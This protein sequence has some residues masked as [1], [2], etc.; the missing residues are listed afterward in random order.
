MT[1]RLGEV[2]RDQPLLALLYGRGDKG[3]PSIYCRRT[4]PHGCLLLEWYCGQSKLTPGDSHA[5]GRLAGHE[6]YNRYHCHTTIGG[7]SPI[8]RGNDLPLH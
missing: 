2:M 8:S 6:P 3:E 5:R 1:L 4:P 7:V